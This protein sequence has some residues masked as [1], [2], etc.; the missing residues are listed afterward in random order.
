MI[1][2]DT[3]IWI[4]HL[5]AGHSTL[6]GLLERG[7]V[8]G[9]PWVIGELALGHLGRRREILG[10][11][12]S[13]PQAAVASTDEILTLV[14]NHGLFGRGIGYVDAQLLAATYL[15]PD[16]ELWTADRPLVAAASRMG[17]AF[18]PTALVVDGK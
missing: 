2:V 15:T 6:A 5:R 10:L 16:A 14:E 9:H 3:S 13:L 1:L 12:T 8:L 7:L 18:D 17:C 11:L 4:G